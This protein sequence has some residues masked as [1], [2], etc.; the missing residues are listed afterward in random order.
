MRCPKCGNEAQDDA[1]FCGVCYEVLRRKAPPSALPA[2]S[3][4]PVPEKPP[5]PAAPPPLIGL[6]EFRLATGAALLPALW[7]ASGFKDILPID[8]TWARVQQL[9]VLGS[10]NLAF[11]EA[12]HVLAM[13]SGSQFVIAAA[14]SVFQTLVPLAC[15]V[16]FWLK[17]SRA[18]VLFCLF[19][20][21]HNLVD[22][23]FYLADAKLQALIL[24]E[25]RS[26]QEGGFHDWAYVLDA[27]GARS[28]AQSYGRLLFFVGNWTMGTVLALALAPLAARLRR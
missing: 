22:W 13:P 7:F 24:L 19:W 2:G 1:A 23:S 4:A 21:G 28:R 14:G 6:P 11:H 10:V 20:T 12:G 3:Q 25:G 27:L 15:L 5:A 26:G 17:K 18:G 16:H 9:L 8:E